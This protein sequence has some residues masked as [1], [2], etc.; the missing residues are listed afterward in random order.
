VCVYKM[1]LTPRWSEGDKP[2][3]ETQGEGNG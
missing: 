3:P 2:L 1:G